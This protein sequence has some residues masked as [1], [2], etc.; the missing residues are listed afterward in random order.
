MEKL[1]TLPLLCHA[2]ENPVFQLPIRNTLVIASN[3][4]LQSTRTFCYERNKKEERIDLFVSLTGNNVE[5]IF[6]NKFSLF[7]W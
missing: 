6:S 1:A 3:S 2:R 5:D 7:L 4:H